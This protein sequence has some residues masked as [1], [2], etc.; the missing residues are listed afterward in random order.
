MAILKIQNGGHYSSQ[1]TCLHFLCDSKNKKISIHKMSCKYSH[2]L[3]SYIN[4]EFSVAVILNIQNGG[5][6]SSEI[7]CLHF[8]YDSNNK[9]SIHKMSC[10]DDNLNNSGVWCPLTALLIWLFLAITILQVIK[11][12]LLLCRPQSKCGFIII[13][14]LYM[15]IV[16]C[17]RRSIFRVC[18][19]IKYATNR[20]RTCAGRSH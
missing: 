4:F 11:Q 16:H 9:K 3:Q 19:K 10:F 8:L 17:L 5:H 13:I 1:I 20:I 6:Y 18:T 2:V 15:F 14:Y 12:G 7:T